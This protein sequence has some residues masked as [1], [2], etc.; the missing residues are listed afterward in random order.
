MEATQ[1]SPKAKG[2]MIRIKLAVANI[3]LAGILTFGVFLTS[4]YRFQMI[5]FYAIWLFIVAF[6]LLGLSALFG[7][8]GIS[9]TVRSLTVNNDWPIEK[10]VSGWFAWQKG[11]LC[12]AWLLL[13]AALIISVY[14]RRGPYRPPQVFPRSQPSFQQPT[15]QRPG[16]PGG[17][18]E[19]LTPPGPEAPAE[20]GKGAPPSQQPAPGAPKPPGGAQPP[21]GQQPP[22]GPQPSPGAPPRTPPPPPGG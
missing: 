14:V 5:S 3:V 18:G 16:P 7:A 4:A 8:V 10:E 9:K 15:P 12:L 6:I 13:I 2:H 17:L 11:F 22:R 19:R 1:I 21:S 20:A